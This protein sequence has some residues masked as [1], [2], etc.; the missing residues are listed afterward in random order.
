M[1]QGVPVQQ[2]FGLQATWTALCRNLD[3]RLPNLRILPRDGVYLGHCGLVHCGVARQICTHKMTAI[4]CDDEV[5][6]QCIRATQRRGS[7]NSAVSKVVGEVT[8][9]MI[10]LRKDK[11]LYEEP[12]SFE[13]HKSKMQ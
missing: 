8:A 1:D 3:A 10:L 7:G 13:N 6:L 2:E 4:F 5:L 9:L 11:E 12:R